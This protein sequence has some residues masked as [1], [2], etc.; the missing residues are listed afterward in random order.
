[1]LKFSKSAPYIPD[2]VRARPEISDEDRARAAENPPQVVPFHCKPWLDGQAL[3]WT[4]F[5]G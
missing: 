3:G 2:P 5:Y 4:L 1:M